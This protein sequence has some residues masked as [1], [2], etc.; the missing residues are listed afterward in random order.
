LILQL[1]RLKR[2]SQQLNNKK[3]SAAVP[4]ISEVLLKIE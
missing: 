1:S 3:I 2:T 4:R